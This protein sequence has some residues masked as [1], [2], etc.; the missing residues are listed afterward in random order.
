[1]IIRHFAPKYPRSITPV[2]LKRPTLSSVTNTWHDV[3]CKNC[4][5]QKGKFIA[6]R[7]KAVEDLTMK[8]EILSMSGVK[9]VPVKIK[10]KENHKLVLKTLVEELADDHRKMFAKEDLRNAIR[11]RKRNEKRGNL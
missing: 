8:N 5:R 6:K 11:R 7:N 3:T 2:C 9:T 4:L 10:S 1:M